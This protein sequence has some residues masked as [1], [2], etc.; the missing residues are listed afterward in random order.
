M[1]PCLQPDKGNRPGR[2]GGNRAVGRQDGGA[3]EKQK[4]WKGSKHQRNC[5]SIA[6]SRTH[7]KK[8]RAS[9]KKKTVLSGMELGKIS[10]KEKCFT[11]RD[12]MLYYI[13][14]MRK[15]SVNY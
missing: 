9:S 14:T 5:R 2:Y 10:Q 11:N 7:A 13:K 1:Q 8:N 6:S 3:A 4:T 12:F 15:N